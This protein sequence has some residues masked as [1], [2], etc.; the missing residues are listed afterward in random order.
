MDP[1]AARAE[2]DRP[3]RLRVP[4]CRPPAAGGAT[5]ERDAP[6]GAAAALRGREGRCDRDVTPS[7]AHPP[8]CRERR[9]RPRTRTGAGA[10]SPRVFAA[11]AGSAR[12]ARVASAAAEAGRRGRDGRRVARVR[13]SGRRTGG[14]LCVYGPAARAPVDGAQGGAHRQGIHPQPCPQPPQRCPVALP[15]GGQRLA[16]RG[17]AAPPL[18]RPADG[19]AVRCAG[20][21]LAGA[22]RVCLPRVR[23]LLQHPGAVGHYELCDQH[24]DGA[25]ARPAHG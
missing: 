9:P 14:A 12:A 2:I 7:S 6:P 24:S 21:D 22:P 5:R 17:A 15:S 19:H 1:C 20:A 16:L 4:L 23:R 10:R 13:G 3:A 25:A 8:P 11:G 18:L